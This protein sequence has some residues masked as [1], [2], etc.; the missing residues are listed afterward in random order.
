MSE[1]EQAREILA[2]ATAMY[3]KHGHK[4]GIAR[5]MSSLASIAVFTG[6]YRQAQSCVES[7][8]AIHEET[9]EHHRFVWDRYKRAQIAYHR[10]EYAQARNALLECLEAFESMKAKPGEGWTLFE[11]GRIAL[12]TEDYV[13]AAAYSEQ[14]LAIFRMLG[15]GSEWPMLTLGSAA[16]Y[17]GRLRTARKQ[18]ARC[19]EGFRQVGS[20]SGITHRCCEHARLARLL[21]DYKASHAHLRESWELARLIDARA[22]EAPVLQQGAYLAVAEQQYERAA[23]LLAK[24]YALREEMETPVAPCDRAEY[25]NALAVTREAV[26]EETFATLWSAGRSSSMDELQAG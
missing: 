21:G 13:E 9:G 2:Q 11:L 17:E 5:C 19:L 16:I 25:D 26:G 18:L 6:D 3:R 1:F 20:R 24:V 22:V 15:A 7:A 23:R 10:G 14:S 12:A 8:L 4:G